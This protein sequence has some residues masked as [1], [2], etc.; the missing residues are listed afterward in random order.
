MAASAKLGVRSFREI[1]SEVEGLQRA[2]KDLESSG[3]TSYRELAVA[4]REMSGKIANLRSETSLWGK[5]I[6][7]IKQR[8]VGMIGTAAGSYAAFQ[9]LSGVTT[10]IKDADS[11]AFTLEASLRA[12]N[13]EFSNVG[14]ADSW[15]G[16]IE[17]LSGQLRIYSQA[18]ITNASAAT[19]DMTKRLVCL[20]NR[21]RG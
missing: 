8:W 16:A 12:A 9:A 13:R 20:Q 17:R 3:T 6:D 1:D 21:W 14:S 2:Y 18:E 4:K 10:I 15:S 5:G 7:N 19:V 11:A